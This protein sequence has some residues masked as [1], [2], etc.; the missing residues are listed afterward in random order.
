MPLTDS[1]RRLSGGLYQRSK[2][3]TRLLGLGSR[4]V[5]LLTY[6]DC[7]YVAFAGDS[8]AYLLH[9]ARLTQV[10]QD[11]TTAAALVRD[12][13]LSHEAADTV[14]CAIP[15]RNTW[16]SPGRFARHL[17]PQAV[18]SV[19]GGC[20]VRT[21][22]P[23]ACRTGCFQEMLG[24]CPDP[25]TACREVLSAAEKADGSDNMTAIVVDIEAGTPAKD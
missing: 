10:T 2:S 4:V 20:S 13:H 9:G 15:L 12:G 24:R 17:F 21:G 11:Q 19:I 1:L 3:V 23:R 8:R 6:E 22:S 25:E 14:P 18:Q 7:G 5:V 16:A